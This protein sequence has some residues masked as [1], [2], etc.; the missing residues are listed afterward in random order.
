MLPGMGRPGPDMDLVNLVLDAL[1]NGSSQADVA[2]AA[3]VPES[4]VQYW[5]VKFARPPKRRKAPKE[6]VGAPPPDDDGDSL[7]VSRSMRQAMI[8]SAKMAEEVGNYA[9]AQRFMR[10][11]S[12]MQI[13]IA[14]QEKAVQNDRDAVKVPR[15]EI[16]GAI[17]AARARVRALLARPL[18]CEACGHALSVQWAEDASLAKP[19][20][21]PASAPARKQ[22]RVK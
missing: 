2:A 12:S 9:A 15:S 22:G 11:A 14:R 4:T 20:P 10:D 6:P 5:S 8:R 3:G 18:L 1:G 21:A 13:T 16:E 7:A 19:E 17:D